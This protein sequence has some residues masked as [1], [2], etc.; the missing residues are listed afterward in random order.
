MHRE[1]ST[2][3]TF[4]FAFPP[5]D[6]HNHVDYIFKLIARSYARTYGREPTALDRTTLLALIQSVPRHGKSHRPRGMRRNTFQRTYILRG[7]REGGSRL[8]G[9]IK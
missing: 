4:F 7:G 3:L 2:D 1:I 6:Y 9:I 8:Y 5:A